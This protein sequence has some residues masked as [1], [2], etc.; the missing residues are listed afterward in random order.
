MLLDLALAILQPA[1]Y[2]VRTFRD[3]RQALAE[4]PAASPAVLVTDYA[5]AGM[6]G[7]EL[8][9]ACRTVN[10]RQ[11]ALLLSGTVDE[12]IYAN[13]AVKPD[14]FLAKPYRL[15]DLVESVQKLAG[16]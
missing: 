4:F 13:A 1:G 2:D 9:R 15:H 8:L 16:R 14:A 6:N 5:M 10:P 12:T 3:P 7:L 11:K